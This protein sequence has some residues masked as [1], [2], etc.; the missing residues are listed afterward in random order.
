MVGGSEVCKLGVLDTGEL[1]LM[2]CGCRKHYRMLTLKAAHEGKDTLKCKV[3]RRELSS[4]ALAAAQVLESLQRVW[5]YE[6]RVLREKFGALHFYIP[7]LRLAVEVDGEEHFEGDFFNEPKEHVQLRDVRKVLGA[8]NKGVRMLRVPYWDAP[9]FG[10][11]LGEAVKECIAY[12]N[13]RF[14]TWSTDAPGEFGLV[15]RTGGNPYKWY[16]KWFGGPPPG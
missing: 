12:P 6:S 4:H 16:V 1:H 3:C 10:G 13:S 14:A 8:W 15:E 5:V 2:R 9:D 7:E 11:K